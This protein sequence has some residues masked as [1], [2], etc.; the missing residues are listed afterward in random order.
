VFC[1]IQI[2]GLGLFPLVGCR[3]LIFG[4]ACGRPFNVKGL[5]G[6]LHYVILFSCVLMLPNEWFLCVAYASGLGGW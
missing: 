4:V 1:F 6:A 3:S 2:F 5:L